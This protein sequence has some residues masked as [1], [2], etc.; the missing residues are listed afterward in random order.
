[1]KMFSVACALGLAGISGTALADPMSRETLLELTRMKL[2]D[3]AIVAKIEA[4]KVDFDVSTS[5]MVELKKQG[6]SS[7]VIAAAIGNR[8]HHTIKPS[9]TSPD[10]QVP[11]PAGFYAF[12]GNR[13][14]KMEATVTTQA[15][16]GGIFGAALTGGIASVS[17][18]ATIQNESAKVKMGVQPQFF[19]FSAE[20]NGDDGGAWAS[21]A[22]TS[23]NSPAELILTKLTEK[24][25]RREARIG[26]RNI[27]GIKTGVMDKDRIPFTYTVIRPGVYLIDVSQALD[28]G[29]YGFLY[30]LAGAGSSGAL[31]ARIFDFSVH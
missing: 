20:S 15:K 30:A 29:E 22:N 4:D 12:Y 21:G 31:T 13:M 1:M 3:E 26:S 19:F 25:G 11:H 9:L 16:T 28:G 18:K 14:E 6:V 5:D 8:Y 7:P 24:Q 23:V 2:G 27:A 10:P 17:I